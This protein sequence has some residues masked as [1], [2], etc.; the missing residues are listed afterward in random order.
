MA[1]GDGEGAMIDHCFLKSTL[2]AYFPFLG[3]GLSRFACVVF[4]PVIRPSLPASRSSLRGCAFSP[5]PSLAPLSLLCSLPG[6]FFEE[7]KSLRI[8]QRLE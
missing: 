8:S 2:F 4:F 6:G 3:P 1:S 5:S 7:K